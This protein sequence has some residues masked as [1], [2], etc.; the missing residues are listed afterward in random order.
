MS[1]AIWKGMDFGRTALAIASPRSEHDHEPPSCNCLLGRRCSIVPRQRSMA[2]LNAACVRPDGGAKRMKDNE[3][4]GMGM[5]V[6][7]RVWANLRA[8]CDVLCVQASVA[9]CWHPGLIKL[10]CHAETLTLYDPVDQS[11]SKLG[12]F[13]AVWRCPQSKGRPGHAWPWLAMAGHGWPWLAMCSPDILH[14]ASENRLDDGFHL[15]LR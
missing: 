8:C 13:M 14:T 1:N 7:A 5:I 15:L 3:G 6:H 4:D 2:I 12:L 10:G 11:I 9:A